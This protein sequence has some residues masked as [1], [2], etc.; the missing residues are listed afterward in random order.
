M[1][2]K[3]VEKSVTCQHLNTINGNVKNTFTKRISIVFTVHRQAFIFGSNCLF[4]RVDF[5]YTVSAAEII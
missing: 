4:F 2:I 3:F 1:K 5:R